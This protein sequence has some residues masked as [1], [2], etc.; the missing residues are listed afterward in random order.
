MLGEFSSCV[1]MQHVSIGG[2]EPLSE[3]GVVL[4]FDV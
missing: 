3:L 4:I 2:A 1:Y